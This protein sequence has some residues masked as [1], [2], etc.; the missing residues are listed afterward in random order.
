MPSSN[1]EPAIIAFI[2]GI[3]PWYSVIAR[4]IVLVTMLVLLRIMDNTFCRLVD[5]IS[6]A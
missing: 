3:A 1:M 2:N 4:A 6:R 5:R